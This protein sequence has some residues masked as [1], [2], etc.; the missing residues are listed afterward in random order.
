MAP[1]LDIFAFLATVAPM[2]AA[3]ENTSAATAQPNSISQSGTELSALR[4]EIGSAAS[5]TRVLDHWCVSHHLAPAGSVIA[6]K[7][8]NKPV[9]PTGQLRRL[10]NLKALERLQLRH[11][12]LRCNGHLL[13]VAKLWYVPSRL[14]ETM[15]ASLQETETPFG[16]VVAPLHLDRRST[17]SPS[18]LPVLSREKTAGKLPRILFS[19]RALLSQADGLPIAYVVED[20]QRGLL[21]LES[22]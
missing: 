10:L 9:Q 7:I 22:H 20:Y 4:D 16:K 1:L 19:Q 2:T 18:A 15:E 12:Q 13:S 21:D 17:G 5:A 11:V 14:P 3:A 6:E 8:A